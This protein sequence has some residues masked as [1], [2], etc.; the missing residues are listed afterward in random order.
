MKFF[1]ALVNALKSLTNGKVNCI[2]EV[3]GILETPRKTKQIICKIYGIYKK[4]KNLK[5]RKQFFEKNKLVIKQ[6]QQ[7]LA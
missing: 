1:L 3:M 2:T 6:E 5:L 7:H 4:K